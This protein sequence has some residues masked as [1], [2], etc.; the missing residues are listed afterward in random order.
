MSSWEPVLFNETHD[1]ASG[2]M[3]DHVYED[4]VG[5]Y[6][7]SERRAGAIIASKWDVLG[8]QASIPAARG[9]RCMVFNPL[10]W[11]RTD[12]ATVDL[13][14]GEGGVTGVKITDPE[15]QTVPSQIVES[16]RYWDGGLKTARVVF[17]ARDVPAIGY[18][19]FHAS[20]SKGS[21]DGDDRADAIP[22]AKPATGE[23]IL[24]NELYRVSIDPSSGAITGLFYKPCELAGA[25][26]S[27][28][29]R[30]A[31]GRPRRSLGALPRLGRWKPD[32][33]DQPAKSACPRQ[34]GVQRRRQ[35]RA[36]HGAHRPGRLRV[37]RRTPV[38]LRQVRHRD[39]AHSRIAP[40]RGDDPSGQSGEVRSLPGTLPDDDQGGQSNSRDSLWID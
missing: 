18:R 35:G 8:V 40:H 10:G 20:P 34:S 30:L 24:E 23:T 17:I 2:V 15:G 27:R 6:A 4:T 7:Y 11:K 33:H 39:Q 21:A 32:R 37:P 19:M 36:G 28:Q 14:F 1:L 13:G 38:R 25:L 3:T 9:R 31:R 5:S 26:R 16:T 22:T 12:A 29:R